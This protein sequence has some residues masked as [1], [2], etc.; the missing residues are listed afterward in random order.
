MDETEIKILNININTIKSKLKTL[1]AKQTYKGLVTIN[2]F[3]FEDQKISKSKSILRLRKYGN[4][5]EITHKTK[6]K[7]KGKFKVRE[8]TETKV[9]DFGSTK[10]IFKKIG[11]KCINECEKIR[12][13]YVLGKVKIE[14]DQHPKIPAYMEIEGKPKDIE[15]LVK[16]LGFEMDDTCNLTSSMVLKKYGANQKNL[17]FKHR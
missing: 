14:L 3:D 2:F 11:L 16:K 15:K 9:S 17:K 13:S 7:N 1:G 12:T 8:E 6:R 4:T 10:K 5:V